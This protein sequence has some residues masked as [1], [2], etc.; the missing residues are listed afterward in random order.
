MFEERV[1]I[2]W[3]VK[4]TDQIIVF[5]RPKKTI[6]FI[7]KEHIY[8]YIYIY[9]QPFSVSSYLTSFFDEDKFSFI[10]ID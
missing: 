9:I 6:T 10:A 5:I 3:S 1:I 7:P 8:I 4:S 2:C